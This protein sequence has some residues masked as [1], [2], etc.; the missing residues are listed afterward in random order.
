MADLD[1]SPASQTA[2]GT[3]TAL[4][5]QGTGGY[6]FT[7]YEE[8]K[9]KVNQ[10]DLVHT[11]R[12]RRLGKNRA[13]RLD[14]K[15]KA[16]RAGNQ[17]KSEEDLKSVRALED[18]DVTKELTQANVK[19]RREGVVNLILKDAVGFA[20]SLATLDPTGLGAACGA[21]ISSAAGL[22]LM[23][24]KIVVSVRQS[25]RDKGRRGYNI[26]KSTANKEQRRH[27]LSVIMFDRIKE[28][29][30]FGFHGI[31]S[32]AVER[33]A[34]TAEQNNA[35]ETG[36]PRYEEMEDRVAAMGVSGP[37]LRADSAAKM[38]RTMRLGFYRDVE[39]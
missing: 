8:G 18:Y 36:T 22:A 14:E 39:T 16:M 31:T 1:T 15:T 28:L 35:I 19:R 10:T 25:G 4:Q 38:V 34:V 29:K 24:K 21:A 9:L 20:T 3:Q 6:T 33:D 12:D 7:R 23:T 5:L 13:M 32:E 17:G 11:V 37:L 26:N 2:P 30:S 27:N